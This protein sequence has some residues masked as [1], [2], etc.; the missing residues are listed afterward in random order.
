LR[1][2]EPERRTLPELLELQASIYRDKPLLKVADVIRSFNQTRDGAAQAAATLAQA[3]VTPGDRV[4]VMCANRVELLDVF[5]GC[6]WLGAVAVPLNVALRGEQLSHGLINS[7]AR[8]LIIDAQLITLINAIEPPPTLERIWV[9]G[10]ANPDAPHRTPIQ[11]AP[12]LT[13][14]GLSLPAA[15]VDSGT[16]L[17]ILYTSGT[18]GPSKGVCCPHAQFYWWGVGAGEML[19]LSDQDVLYTCLPLFHINALSTLVQALVAGAT[20]VVGDR[21][22][23]SGFWRAVREADA[24]VTYLLGAMVSILWSQPPRADDLNHRVR[25]AL[26]PATPASLLVPF[27]ERFGVR[28]IDGYG[29]TETNACIAARPDRQ[30]PGLIGV[31]RDD[32]EADVVDEQDV[33]VPDGAA[34]ELVL[35]PRHP[36]SF[37]TGYFGMPEATVTA[38]RNLW[39]HTGDRVIRSEDGWFRFIDRLKDA[40]RRRGENISSYEVEQVL[41]QHP[42]VA[43]AAVFA[44]PAELGEDEVMA[45]IITK[46][47]RRVDPAELLD[48]CQPRLAYFAVPRYVEFV[49]ELPM[50]ENGKVRKR[51]LRERGVTASA[52]DREA[53]GYVLSKAVDGAA[54]TRQQPATGV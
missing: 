30:R 17:T 39:F 9:L 10:A 8:L 25:I 27:E 36:F 11:P 53:A 54:N 4:A 47:G 16:T 41:L 7:G 48:H 13:G 34:G 31:V 19:E 12:P 51:V 28:L 29:S 35:R 43:S 3:G 15:D 32:F 26:A 46:P 38:W 52:W 21:F 42:A 44:V 6:A 22:S 23:A 49:N 5:L 50:T 45:A 20:L 40:I 33:S 18:T 24:T 2:L 37:A 14:G 1:G